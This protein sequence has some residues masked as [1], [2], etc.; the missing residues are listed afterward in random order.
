MNSNAPVLR[1]VG[2][3]WR[4]VHR[5]LQERFAERFDEKTFQDLQREKI[6]IKGSRQDSAANK[7]YL[8][9]KVSDYV[10]LK[11]CRKR[12]DDR[13]DSWCWDVDRCGNGSAGGSVSGMATSPTVSPGLMFATPL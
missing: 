11:L 6:S 5:T 13:S 9:R 10:H 2:G 12:R 1:R 3:G 7:I 4:F 8:T